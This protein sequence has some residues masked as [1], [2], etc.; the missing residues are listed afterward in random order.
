MQLAVTGVM[1]DKV[2]LVALRFAVP[3]K[4]PLQSFK[5][6]VGAERGWFDPLFSVA[7]FKLER[8]STADLLF[9]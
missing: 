2:M 8:R 9:E 3:A 4:L 1:S 5:K 7:D 6:L